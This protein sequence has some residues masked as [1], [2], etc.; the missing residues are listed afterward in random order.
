MQSVIATLCGCEMF[1]AIK[2]FDD[3]IIATGK[4][5]V[6]YSF[7]ICVKRNGICNCGTFCNSEL[8]KH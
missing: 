3:A 4:S 2:E 1:P 7:C 6:V 8:F 5:R